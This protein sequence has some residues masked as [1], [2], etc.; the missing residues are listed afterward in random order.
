MPVVVSLIKRTAQ[1]SSASIVTN[2]QRFRMGRS[3]AWT[4]IIA[5]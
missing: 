4:Y 5:A 2:S 3:V 1:E